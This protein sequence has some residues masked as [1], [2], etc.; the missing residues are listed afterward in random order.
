MLHALAHLRIVEDRVAERNAAAGLQQ[1]CA[2]G[3]RDGPLAVEV[4]RLLVAARRSDGDAV[5]ERRRGPR[6]GSARHD[7]VADLADDAGLVGILQR[8]REAHA[9]EPHADL[10]LQEG[11]L[12]FGPVEAGDALRRRLGEQALIEPGRLDRLGRIRRQ[13]ALGVDRIDAVSEEEAR[14]DRN[15]GILEPAGHEAVRALLRVGQR[16]GDLD[17]IVEGLRVGEAFLGEE[18]LVPIKHPVVDR[19]RQR[20]HLAL[21]VLGIEQAG[22]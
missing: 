22:L 11:R 21:L 4:G 16:L 5:A 9:V 10:T 3:L 17:E 2:L 12:A 15:I 18:L 20:V 6:L 1:A 14:E 13:V 7:A 19:E 8:R